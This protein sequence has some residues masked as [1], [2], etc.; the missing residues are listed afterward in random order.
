MKAPPALTNVAASI[1]QRL[2][3]LSRAQGREFQHV[4]SDFAIET[5]G[6]LKAFLLPILDSLRNEAVFQSHWPAGGPWVPS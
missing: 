3:N 6:L 5:A 1:R 2:L 4:L